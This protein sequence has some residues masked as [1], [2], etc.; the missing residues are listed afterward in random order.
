MTSFRHFAGAFVGLCLALLPGE[1][2]RAQTKAPLN[3]GER[4]KQGHSVHGEAFDT[5]PRTKPWEMTG[6]GK[7]HFP[8]TTKNPE[9]QKWFDQGHT[10]LHSFWDSE[11]ERSVRYCLKL[12]PENA[13]C[14][15][16]LARATT[17][18]RSDAFL[19]EAVKRKATVSER[20]RLYIDA[21]EARTRPL[22]LRDR[23]PSSPRTEDA[24]YKKKLETICLR[25]P[26]DLEAKSLLAYA[27][28]GEARYGT[29]LIVREILAKDPDHPGAHHY[30]IHNWN[31]HE[32]EKALMS[33]RRYGDIAP[34][35]AHARHMPGHIYSTVGMWDEAAIAMESATRVEIKNMR[36]RLVFPFNHWNYGHNRAYLSYIQGQ[37][38]MA[39]AALFG[40]RQL[41]AAPL[42]PKLNTDSGYSSHSQGIRH[43]LQT[44]VK[45]ERWDA[46]LDAQTIPWRDIFADKMNKAYAHTRAYIG[47]G[48]L[49]KAEK[50]L[51]EHEA[52]KKD[53]GANPEWK[54]HYEIERQELKARV[55]LLRRETL[56]GLALLG[57]AAERQFQEQEDDNDPPT[58]PELLYIGLGRAYLEAKSPALAVKAFD[59]ALEVSRNDWLSLS[60][61]VHAHLALGQKK[62]AEDALA[63]LLYVTAEADPGLARLGGATQ[64]ARAAGLTASARDSSPES[65]R[66]YKAATLDRVGPIV[67][68][69]YEAP[70][71]EATDVAGKRVSLDDY[72]GQNVI[73]VFY[74]GREC[75][76]CMKQLKDVAGKSEDWKRKDAVVLAVSANSPEEN[77][78]ASE[79]LAGAHLLSDR[80]HENARRFASYD[81][82]EEMELHSTILVD[83][84]GRVHWGHTGGAPFD[85]LAFLE[86]QLERMNSSVA[87]TPAAPSV[88]TT[89]SVRPA[90]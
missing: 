17:G 61:L 40:A 18:E 45:F 11:A 68:E 58:Y 1:G 77:E 59:K 26:D 27:N 72:R 56:P 44:L 39:E 74:L 84:K 60:G 34:N 52:L 46:L 50:A 31:Y 90:K 4:A 15:W 63:R 16:G 55:L 89:A 7:A 71:L 67:W 37:L 29:E 70:R 3:A 78:G 85:D 88:A 53:M 65:Q 62:E 25:Y 24:E 10:L 75:V 42:D 81:D 76:H 6:I 64:A 28:M 13:M 79:P 32:P 21:V 30:R 41:V 9:V 43:L 69:P 35:I 49:P 38:G 82:F 54:E 8:I 33:C 86:K 87:A 83:K 80:D 36:E 2:L 66:R 23:T 73:L 22:A 20:E 48:D 57:E 5:G 47:K 14:Y 12:E 19:R 51:A